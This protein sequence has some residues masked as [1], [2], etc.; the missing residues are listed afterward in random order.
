MVTICVGGL[1]RTSIPITA[2]TTWWELK[3]MI[4][5]KT[6]VPV[7]HQRLTPDNEKDDDWTPVGLD[8]GDD[9]LCE[10]GI[11]DHGRHPLHWAAEAGNAEAVRLWV[12]SGASVDSMN[13]ARGTPLM[14]ASNWQHAECVAEMLRLGADATRANK[15]GRTALHHVARRGSD[16]G[17]REVVRLLVAAGCDPEARDTSGNTAQEHAYTH[18]GDHWGYTIASWIRAAR[19]SRGDPCLDD[20]PPGAAAVVFDVRR[21]LRLIPLA[22]LTPQDVD[23]A[24]IEDDRDGAAPPDRSDASEEPPEEASHRTPRLADDSHDEHLSHHRA[25]EHPRH[26]ATRNSAGGALADDAGADA[27]A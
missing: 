14:I 23:Q 3:S 11:L 2:K 13:M 15:Y 21:G 20:P 16:R 1:W 7:H 25:D 17:G 22:M 8:D 12:A 4:T 6:A 18:H 9:V 24:W 10:W 27:S 19:V 5:R 26:P